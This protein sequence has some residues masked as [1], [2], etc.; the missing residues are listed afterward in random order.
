ML[1]VLGR[2]KHIWLQGI[3]INLPFFGLK[4]GRLIQINVSETQKAKYSDRNR[5]TKQYQRS[6]FLP[7]SSAPRYLLYILSMTMMVI[8]FDPF[9]PFQRR[10]YRLSPIKLQVFP[11]RS[12][13]CSYFVVVTGL[14]LP[15]SNDI[16]SNVSKQLLLSTHL[17]PNNS[18]H[19]T[20]YSA[21]LVK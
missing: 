15:I 18:E 1:A 19:K 9:Q 3:C 11:T 17:V 20:A 2:A 16:S 8:K 14:L 5:K 6:C 10:I 21:S 7:A 13:P 4:K 12:V